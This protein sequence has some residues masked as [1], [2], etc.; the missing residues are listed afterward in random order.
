MALP[1]DRRMEVDSSLI[2]WVPEAELLFTT[3]H[4][5]CDI[6]ASLSSEIP[7][8]QAI[9]LPTPRLSNQTQFSMLFFVF[10]F[11]A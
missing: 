5:R 8:P 3:Y 4:Q 7:Y 6:V 2:Y 1:R 10:L 9:F 11:Q